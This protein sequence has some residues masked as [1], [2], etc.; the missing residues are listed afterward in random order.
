MD[1][2]LDRILTRGKNRITNI[3]TNNIVAGVV[4][5]GDRMVQSAVVQVG[6]SKVL[7]VLVLIYIEISP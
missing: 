1:L 3:M 7:L 2:D 6:Q 5:A 4:I